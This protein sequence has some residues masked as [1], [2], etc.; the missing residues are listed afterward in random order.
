MFLP[1]I[2]ARLFLDVW[3][4]SEQSSNAGSG[5]LMTVPTPFW[6]GED[7]TPASVT[8][9]CVTGSTAVPPC[10]WPEIRLSAPGVD[11]PKVVSQELSLIA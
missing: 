6:S 1:D 9:A 7:T 3:L 10:V 4:L 8:F 2:A 11:G 5:S